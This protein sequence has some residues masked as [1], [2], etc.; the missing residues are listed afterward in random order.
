MPISIVSN[1]S[2]AIAQ[3]NLTSANSE[4]QRSISKI[5]SGQRVF[6]AKEDAAALSIGSGLQ[7]DSA[8]LRAASI[9][10]SSGVSLM[11]IADGALSQ[12][13]EILTRMDTL[14][15]QSQSG[16]ITNT[17]RAYLDEEFQNLKSELDR[18]ATTTEFNGSKL[19]GGVNSVELNNLGA[20]IDSDDGFVGFQIQDF[21]NPASVFQVEYNSAAGVMTLT[22][23]TTSEAQSI[24]VQ[25][26]TVGRLNEYNFQ[27]L[28]VTL[29][30]NSDFDSATDIVHAGAGEEFDVSL[31]ASVTASTYEFQIGR[32]TAA[33]DRV[34]VSLPVIN[35][36][37]MGLTLSN[38]AAQ[39]DAGFA[40]DAIK[41][42]LDIVVSARSNLGASIN[43]MEVASRNIQLSLENTESARSALLDADIAAEITNVTAKQVLLEAGTDM[44]NRANQT[45]RILLDLVRGA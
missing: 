11:Q 35:V 45:P 33:E 4:A 25:T 6:N 39:S 3:R 20:N 5:S 37:Q 24:A 12:I 30:L 17:E 26:P 31:S 27:S 38:V 10:A 15:V 14:A 44:L 21:V 1:S 18:I 16:Q 41:N 23:Q 9:N 32:T 42:A 19:L 34:L 7:V 22:N 40:V 28:G 8:S 36:D 2:S 43:R 29:T 13:S